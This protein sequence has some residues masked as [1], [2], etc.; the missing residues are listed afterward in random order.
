MSFFVVRPVDYA[1]KLEVLNQVDTADE[2]KTD[3]IARAGR[4]NAAVMVFEVVGR[5]LPQW[6][7]LRPLVA[8]GVYH[9]PV[10][11]RCKQCARENRPDGDCFNC[12]IAKEVGE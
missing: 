7:D 2:A 8:P 10:D 9:G 12:R 5:S 6:E 3:A 4:L 11:D 1:N